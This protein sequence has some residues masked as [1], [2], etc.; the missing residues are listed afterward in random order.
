[1]VVLLNL[2]VEGPREQTATVLCELSQSI[3]YLTLPT[4]RSHDNGLC[5]L[6]VNEM[7]YCFFQFDFLQTT[8]LTLPQSV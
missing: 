1:M 4:S 3:T 6:Y 8:S 2:D 7:E 5:V